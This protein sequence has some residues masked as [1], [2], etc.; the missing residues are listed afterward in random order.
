MRSLV[1]QHTE[2]EGPGTL[3]LWFR[4]RALPFHVHHWY[5]NKESPDAAKF[6]CLVI[7]GGPMNV[8]QEAEYPWL[9]EEK[10]FLRNWIEK[11]KPV[12]GICLGGQMLAQALGGTVSKN[13]QREIGFHTITRHPISYPEI[14]RAHV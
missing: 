3:E 12:L 11:Q 5:R 1:F 13:P 6:D 7:L 10:S 4:E 14:G 8:N 2:E 9:S